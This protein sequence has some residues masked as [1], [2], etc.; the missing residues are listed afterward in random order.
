MKTPLGGKAYNKAY[1]EL[2]RIKRLAEGFDALMYKRVKML[3]WE[4]G[5]AADAMFSIAEKVRPINNTILSKLNT[6]L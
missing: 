6:K 4:H 3:T 2:E 5:S 1:D